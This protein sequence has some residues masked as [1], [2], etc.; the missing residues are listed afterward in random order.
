MLLSGVDL[1]EAH[2]FYER[3]GFDKNANVIA[4]VLD[5][6]FGFHEIGGITPAAQAGNPRPRLFRLAAEGALI[7]RMGFNNDGLDAIADRIAAAQAGAPALSAG[8]A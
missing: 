5:I 6:G 8:S 2:E 1:G 7:N 3:N 4:G